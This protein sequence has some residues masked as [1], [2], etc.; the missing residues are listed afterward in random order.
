MKKCPYIKNC[1][2]PRG[3]CYECD[4]QILVQKYEKKIARL[5]KKIADMQA[6]MNNPPVIHDRRTCVKCGKEDAHTREGY[7]TCYSCAVKN[8][9]RELAYYYKNRERVRKQQNERRAKMREEAG[10]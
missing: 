6:Q 7:T 8:A 9:E 3:T 4:L 5:N 1:A 2:F 10:K